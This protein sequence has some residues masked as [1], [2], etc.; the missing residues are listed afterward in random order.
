[1]NILIRRCFLVALFALLFEIIEMGDGYKLIRPY[2]YYQRRPWWRH[3]S[4]TDHKSSK[5][6]HSKRISPEDH[7]SRR[8]SYNRRFRYGS[9]RDDF[10]GGAENHHPYTIVI[11]LPKEE[12]KYEDD[13]YEKRKRNYERISIP[14]YTIENDYIEDEDDIESKVVNVNNKK[15]QIKMIKGENPKLHIKISRSDSDKNIE[16]V[17]KTNTTEVNLPSLSRTYANLTT[18]VPQSTEYWAPTP[19]FENIRQ[20]RL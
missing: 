5:F 8:P 1:M 6:Y 10:D 11:Q 14:V 19:H 18:P 7:Y 9:T 15:M 12:D 20:K 4:Y 13:N 3:R 16:I 17:D 2:K